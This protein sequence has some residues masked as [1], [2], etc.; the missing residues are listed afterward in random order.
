MD[1]VEQ[2]KVLEKEI[3]EYEKSIGLVVPRK[4][5]ATLEKYLTFG[6]EDLLKLDWQELAEICLD[7]SALLIYLQKEINKHRM[8]AQWCTNSIEHIVGEQLKN[9][10][11]YTY[12]EKFV[13]AV[14][15]MDITRKLFKIQQREQA[16]LESGSY[17]IQRIESWL[18]YVSDLKYARRKE[19]TEKMHA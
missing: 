11:G 4:N 13:E 1:E 3:E 7:V 18:N 10:K 5:A 16:V 6:G 9:Y 14:P 12:K 15:H 19:L 17:L 2:L 8:R